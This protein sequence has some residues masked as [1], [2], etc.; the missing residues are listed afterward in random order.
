MSRAFILILVLTVFLSFSACG[1][2]GGTTSPTE[3]TYTI[4]GVVSGLSGT[5]L[6]LQDNGI[7]SL[8]ISANGNFT[9]EKPVASGGTYNVT[10]QVEPHPV[11][12][13]LVTN[14]SG[15]ARRECYER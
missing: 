6:M 12:L 8:Q 15:T 10:I 11:Q 9:F 4:G 13:C 14:G 7:D 1:G 3:T 2:S 5:G